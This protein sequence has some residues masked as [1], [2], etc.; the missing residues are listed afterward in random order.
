MRAA[1]ALLREKRKSMKQKTAW[2]RIFSLLCVFV[3]L[4]ISLPVNAQEDASISGENQEAPAVQE[5]ASAQQDDQQNGAAGENA[6]FG[7]MYLQNQSKQTEF[8]YETSGAYAHVAVNGNYKKKEPSVRALNIPEADGETVLEAWTVDGMNGN[9]ELAMTVQIAAMPALEWNESLAFYTVRNDRLG[10]KILAD[11]SEND[12]TEL[13][14]QHNKDTGIALVRE[15]TGE[16]LVPEQAI[17]ANDDL[18]LTGKMP[19]NAVVSAVPVKVDIDG[20]QAL[21]AYEISIYANANQ[22]KKGKTWQPADEK[23]QVHFRN[24]DFENVKGAL[25]VYH[26]KDAKAEAEKVAEVRADENG[27]I[28][29]DA[30]SFSIYAVAGVIERDI[31]VEGETWHIAVSYGSDSGIPSEGVE[32]LVKEIKEGDDNY[33]GY[34]D[35]S[36]RK[37]GIEKD[38]IGISRAFDIKIVDAKDHDRIYEPKTEVD[39]EITLVGVDLD[40]YANVGVLHFVEGR[41]TKSLTAVD[42]ENQASGNT[43]RFSTDSFS[44]YVVAGY[45][46]ETFVEA[47]DGNTY[48]I[49]VEYDENAGIPM[50]GTALRVEEILPETD[51]YN[52]YFNESIRAIGTDADHIGLSR[53][54]DIK[55][56][57]ADD[58]DHVYEPKNEVQVS[59]TL[60]GEALK[61][62]ADVHVLHF[63]DNASVSPMDS[64]VSEDTVQFTTDSFSV[65]AVNGTVH[66]RTFHFYVPNEYLEYEPYYLN[67]DFENTV[68]EQIVRSGEMPVAPQNPVNPQDQEATFAGWY[69]GNQSYTTIKQQDLIEKYDFSQPLELTEDDDVHLYA[70]FTHYYFAIFHD[71][72][73]EETGTF[74]VAFTRRLDQNGT[75]SDFFINVRQYSVAYEDPQN[76]DDTKMVF[77]GWSLA[78][79]TQPGDVF[80]DYGDQVTAVTTD[81]EGRY[82]VNETVHF[83]PIFRAVKWIS[84]YSG[85]SGTH[86]TF[87]TDTYHYDGEGPNSLPGA[88]VM[89][90]DPDASG[91]PYDFEGWYA[92]ASLDDND[93]TVVAGA[94]KIANADGSLVTNAV[95]AEA[96]IEVVSSCAANSD[97][98]IHLTNPS[99]TLYAH[100]VPRTTAKYSVVIVG[101]KAIDNVGTLPEAEQ[102]EFAEKF[103]YTGTIGDQIE[104][105]ANFEALNTFEGFNALHPGAGLTADTNATNNPYHAY[106]YKNSTYNSQTIAADGSTTIYVR[107]DWQAE[108]KPNLSGVQKTLKFVDSMDPTKT[109]PFTYQ[110]VTYTEKELAYGESLSGYI[111]VNPVSQIS[112]NGLS[113]KGWYADEACTS[114][115]ALTEDEHNSHPDW[116]YYTTMPATDLTIYAGWTREWF[117]VKI[118]PNYGELYKLDSNGEPTIGTGG[119]TWFWKE[120]GDTFQEYTTVKRDYVESDSGSWYYV[121]KD[122]AYYGYPDTWVSGE[123]PNRQTYYTQVPGDATEMSTFQYDPNVYRY[124][125][126]YEVLF[127]DNGN[128]IG[129]ASERYNFANIVDH[130]ITLRLRWMKTGVFYLEYVP[131]EGTLNKDDENETLYLELEGDSY[132]DDADVVVTRIAEPP[133]GYEF[134]GWRIRQDDSGTIYRPGQSFHLL[135]KY[136]ASV[137]GKR[138]VFLDAV[139][140]QVP[141][142]KIVYHANGGTAD[143]TV[144]ENPDNKNEVYGYPVD[145]TYK[146]YQTE[147]DLSQQTIAISR[148]V[149]NS[150]TVLSEGTWLT[151]SDGAVFVGWCEN[152]EMFFDVEKEDTYPLLDGGGTYRVG[153]N[154]GETPEEQTVHLYA[155]WAVDVNYHLNSD[156]ATAGFGTWGDPYTLETKN[157]ETFYTQRACIGSTVDW[158]PYDPV[159]IGNTFLYWAEDSQ[160]N[161]RYDFAQAIEGALDLYA[162]WGQAT[163]PIKVLNTSL[164]QY[165]YAPWTTDGDASITLT[166]EPTDPKALYGDTPDSSLSPE[167]QERQKGWKIYDGNTYILPFVTVLSNEEPKEYIL[168]RHI[169]TLR[170]NAQEGKTY[171]KLADEAEERPLAENETIYYVY[172][173]KRKVNIHYVE[174]ASDGLIYYLDGTHGSADMIVEAQAPR[175]SG[176]NLNGPGTQLRMSQMEPLP[177]APA[178]NNNILSWLNAGATGQ[179][180]GRF[181]CYCFALGTPDATGAENLFLKTN[182][183]YADDTDRPW[184]RIRNTWA[185]FQY[186]RDIPTVPTEE[187]TWRDCEHEISLYVVFYTETPTFV[188]F[189]LET[190]GLASDQFHEFDFDYW[191]DKI[192]LDSSNYGQVIEHTFTTINDTADPSDPYLYHGAGSSDPDGAG[193]I[194]LGNNKTFT[195][196]LLT[197]DAYTYRLTVAQRKK[198]DDEGFTLGLRNSEHTEP[199]AS[200]PGPAAWGTDTPWGLDPGTHNDSLIYVYTA[201][202]PTD[203]DDGS[204]DYGGTHFINVTETRASVNVEFHLAMISPDGSIAIRDDLRSDESEHYGFTLNKGE[205]KALSTALP[206]SDFLQEPLANF[207]EGAVIYGWDRH[208]PEPH[209]QGS[210]DDTVSIV[211]QYTDDVSIA[212]LPESEG[213]DLHHIYIV[214]GAGERLLQ[215]T[216]LGHQLSYHSVEGAPV[217]RLYYLYYPMLTIHYVLEDSDGTLTPIT[218]SEDGVSTVNAITYDRSPLN[219][220]GMLVTPTQ[221]VRMPIEGMTI[222]QEVGV[223]ENGNRIFNI[224]PLL[225]NGTARLDLVYYKLG[226]AVQENSDD[227]KHDTGAIN[228]PGNSG[229]GYRDGN[230]APYDAAITETLT[231]YTKIQDNKLAWKFMDEP[232]WVTIQNW[233]VIYAIYRERGY[234][235]TVVKT[236]TEDT[237]YDEPFTVRIESTAINRDT[238]PVDGTGYSTISATPANGANPGVITFEVKD[239]DA[240]TIIGL[241]PGSYIVTET[242]NEN[243]TLTA[244]IKDT[245]DSNA[246]PADI[247]V[248]GNS[249]VELSGENVL[250]ADMTLTLINA[251]EVI[252]R[253]GTRKFSTISAAVRYIEEYDADFTETIEMLVPEYLMPASDA[254]EI[255]AFLHVTL[256]TAE[257]DDDPDNKITA[258]MTSVIKRKDNLTVPMFSNLGE[259]GFENITLDGN[260]RRNGNDEIIP[261]PSALISNE[262]TLNIADGTTLQNAISSGN[263][264][265]VNS[266]KGTVNMTGGIVTGC[267]AKNGGGIYASAG[268][269]NISGGTFTDNSAEKGGAVY[270]DGSETVTVSGGSIGAEGSPNRAVD[271]GAIYMGSGTIDITGGSISYNAAA[272]SGGGIYAH[273][274]YVN[275][276]GDNATMAHNTAEENG[277]AVCMET[278]TFKLIKGSIT[279]NSAGSNGGAIWSATG[280]VEVSG[281]SMSN[282]TAGQDG[283]AVYTN[284]S[285]FIMTGGKITGNTANQNGGAVYS[286]IGSVSYTGSRG[287]EISG[288][289]ATYGNGGGIC[290]VSGAVSITNNTAKLTG[291]KAENGNGGAVW[292]GSGSATLKNS[293]IGT[294]ATTI[295]PALANKAKNGA[296]V[297]VDTG[298]VTFNEA[299]Y[300]RGNTA[301]AGGA[302]SV[303]DANARV[304]FN[305]N[306][307]IY[308]NTMAGEKSNVY[309]N[310][311]TDAILNFQS[312]GSG[313]NIGIYVSDDPVTVDGKNTT[314]LAQRG[315]PS[316]RFGIYVNNN[317]VTNKSKITNDRTPNLIVKEDAT[318]KKLYW[319]RNFNIKV[320]YVADYTRGLPF[321]GPDYT[322][323]F[324]STTN[325]TSTT[326]GGI[327]IRKADGTPPSYENAV[328]EVAED[329]RRLG[330][331]APS[332]N[333]TS[334]FGNA[335]VQQATVGD[336]H[337]DDYLT[338]ID[339]DTTNNLWN[340]KKR[341]GSIIEGGD[342]TNTVTT[343]I[344]LYTEPYYLSIENNHPTDTLVIDSLNVKVNGADKPVI[345]SAAQTGYGYVFSKND[346]I[347]NVLLPVQASDLALKPGES[348]RILLPGGKGMPYTL[349]GKYYTAYDAEHPED[350][351]ASG[352]VEYDQRLTSDADPIIVTADASVDASGFTIGGTNNDVTPSNS[353]QTHELVFYSDRQ[354]CRVVVNERIQAAGSDPDNPTYL[355]TGFVQEHAGEGATAGK[356]EYTFNS[357]RQANEFITSHHA[358]FY[359]DGDTTTVK[360]TIELLVDYMIPQSEMVNL[361]TGGGIKRDI[362]FQTSVNGHFRFHPEET[363]AEGTV[364]APRATVS[365]GSGNFDSFIKAPNGT[366]SGGDYQDK[367]TVKNLVFDGKNFGGDN[368]KGGIIKTKGWNVEIENVDFINSKAQFGGGIYIES[369]D[370]NSSDKTPRGS[371]TVKNCSFTNCECTLGLDK[372]GGGAVWTSMKT[373]TVE[374]SQFIS[375]K[376]NQQGGALF[377]YVAADGS[378]ESYTVVDGCTFEGCSAGQAAGSMESGATQVHISNT[379][380]RNSTSNAKN[381]GALNIWSG[382]S[383]NTSG[384]PTT[385]SWVYLTGCTFENCYALNGTGSNGNGGAMRSTAKYNTITDCTFINNIGNNGGAINIY[386]SKAIDTIV[387][388]CTFDGCSARCL[389]GAIWCRSNTLTIDNNTSIRNCTAPNEGGAIFHS[390]VDSTYINPANLADGSQ[391]TMVDTTIDTC[392]S[393]TRSGGGVYTSAATVSVSDSIVENC[394]T[395]AENTNG[396]GLYLAGKQTTLSG[397][398]IRNCTATGLGG[399]VYQNN[400]TKDYFTVTNHSVISGNIAQGSMEVTSNGITYQMSGGGIFTNTKTF[401]LEDSSVTDNQAAG[402]GG[403]VCQNYDNEK[404]GMMNM[405][406][407]TVTGNISGGKGGGLF[408]LTNMTLL[409][410]TAVT[411][412]RLR[413]EQEMDA[414]GVYLRNGVTLTLGEAGGDQTQ[415]MFD[416][417]GNLTVDGKPSNLRL[418][419]TTSG[420]IVNANSVKVYCG[421]GG[422]IRVVNAKKKLTRFG[423]AQGTLSNPAGFTDEHKVFWSEDGSLYGI[424]DRQ[425]DTGKKII[426]G[427]D[428][429][430][431]IT[432]G[433]GRLL[434]IDQNH[435]RPAV[436]DRLDALTAAHSTDTTTTSAFSTLRSL[437]D[438]GTTLYYAD[439]TPYTGSAYQVK[440]LVE[441]YTAEYY[442][443]VTGGT[444]KTVTLTTANSNDSLYPYRGRKGT[445]C[446]ITRSTGMTNNKPMITAKAN[447]TL[448]NVVL[449]GNRDNVAATAYTSIIRADYGTQAAIEITLGR[450]ATLQN[451]ET[452]GNG[453]GIYLNYGAKLL[454]TGGSIRNC[455][456]NNGGGVYI[457]GGSGTMTM[458]LGTITKCTATG[459]GGGVYFNKGVVD[460][461]ASPKSGMIK[462]TGG[463]I[464][465]CTAE[466]GGGIYMNGGN[467]ARRL[468][469]SGGSIAQNS[470]TGIGGGIAVGDSNARIYFS[471]APFVYQNTSSMATVG[472]APEGQDPF[473]SSYAK[474]NNIQMDQGFDRTANNPPTVIV[475]R[476]LIRGA[477]IGVYVPGDSY[478]DGLYGNHGA[479]MDPF[480]TFEGSATGGMNYFINDRNGMKGGQLDESNQDDK[481]IYWRKIYSL[482]VT[483]QV[484]S[485]D[486]ADQNSNAVYRFEVQLTGKISGSPDI[487]AE[488]FSGTYGGMIFTKGKAY[489]SLH[490]GESKVAD[491]LPLGFGYTVTELLKNDQKEHFKTSAENDMGEVSLL[492]DGSGYPYTSGEMKTTTKFNY[493]VT[494]YNLHAVCKIVGKNA[495]GQQELLYSYDAATATYTP[496]VYSALVTA[497]N[498]VNAGDSNEWYYKNES[499][500]FERFIPVSHSI[501]MLV[502]EYEMKQPASLMN[503]QKAILTTAEKNADDGFPY[504]GGS[505]SAVIKRAYTGESMLTVEDSS[506]TLGRITIDGQGN[507]FPVSCSGAI[508]E[509][510]SGAS[511]TVGNGTT[512]QNSTTSGNG[513]AICLAEGAAMNISGGPVFVNNVKTG[514]TLGQTPANGS[515]SSVYPGGTSVYQDIYIAGYSGTDA[516]SLTVTGDITSDDGSI[517]V[518]AQDD[519]HF[520]QNQQFA[521]MEGG[522]HSGLGAFRNARPDSQTQNPLKNQEGTPLYLYGVARDGK[523]YWS[524]S[525]NLTISKHITG[526]FAILTDEFSFTVSGLERD[527]QCDYARYTYDGSEWKADTGTGAKGKLTADANG[528]LSGSAL[529]LGNNQRIM[530]SIPRGITVTVTEEEY[531]CYVPGY[532]VQAAGSDPADPVGSN[533]ASNIAMNVDTAVD[534]TNNL[535]PVAPTGYHTDILP[536]LLLLVTGLL[537]AS[538]AGRRRKKER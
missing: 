314:V 360:A 136:M 55:I 98:H 284:E 500:E 473:V 68:Y 116:V 454:M 457:D 73:D 340:F 66:V 124:A 11:L 296:G 110:G 408:T 446:T 373:V 470:V 513:A 514:A 90:R 259:L 207:A 38:S 252:C 451:A 35:E 256:T 438:N 23:V 246:S 503:G 237:G 13:K 43:V 144:I 328:S 521:V 189:D 91:R 100:W 54:F 409:G 158:P 77:V 241:A 323:Q 185:G 344:F 114:P 402:S 16:A 312:L 128:E 519:P 376:A 215:L 351:I 528:K 327:Y 518:W 480:A 245:Q 50:E 380:F 249:V 310:F 198:A 83:Y 120:Y 183:R 436:F 435:V 449:D 156:S 458:M 95:L 132:A 385:D 375:C 537:L 523:V 363:N 268:T 474:A 57:D 201:M 536:F 484:V 197:T 459:N 335:F 498:K 146:D 71:Q 101:L 488:D 82:L 72:Y 193:A 366:L 70:K 342:T 448:S 434:Y 437:D 390:K 330:A 329:I 118:D 240:V 41:R 325:N 538:L 143:R 289:T 481:K 84:Y 88:S 263:G 226:A 200:Y 187:A 472:P 164:N 525:M 127:D 49:A 223:D 292:V 32:L 336:M 355:S 321:D 281:G 106:T 266:L 295:D 303:G 464:S 195:A 111:P 103:E 179:Y 287:S 285:S 33:E 31:Q 18:Y 224:P 425:D 22:M 387:S 202:E 361:S 169:E 316:T 30:D 159:D 337:Y 217:H 427:G 93:E 112:E 527:Y 262:G 162:Q 14:L 411:G 407:A 524:G 490:N 359:P 282:N 163:V 108:S 346:A 400:G 326:N 378:R 9:S 62:Y 204:P 286:N 349:S 431:K 471:G 115:V 297:F 364:T 389:G 386:N 75:G 502:H 151:R 397:T 507:S 506:L 338:R 206:V 501:E 8:Y 433:N 145:T 482:T 367:L 194:K 34:I 274:A 324:Y 119:S 440:M 313:A 150:E 489:F 242:G 231:L 7:V 148:L 175:D 59:I 149:N 374:N 504:V 222:S 218:G 424:V 254:P 463:S 191:I 414:A 487:L 398:T 526:S 51:E 199:E 154:P 36:A 60:V 298:T 3:L 477:S 432:D 406:G 113:F 415:H 64:S 475:S 131:G 168:E 357:P 307:K 393:S 238:Y 381:G 165:D 429:I 76:E 515:D 141:S 140:E 205:S 121:K 230:N 491:L 439:G 247:A 133:E 423:T 334:V 428:P 203:S 219:L 422:E 496:A 372:F 196:F 26:L 467:G 460:D 420:E 125:G 107:Y 157:G 216:E 288:N 208:N 412:N 369:V 251:P 264:A 421:I 61:N 47:S 377:H 233:P 265:A 56:V 350:G 2:N 362:T 394:Y 96:G 117:L 17:W 345:N 290:S 417:T 167:E 135:S 308:D 511:L 492:V 20:R 444:G 6:V 220:N 494:F 210:D 497:F 317:V 46:I 318:N 462:I 190:I 512:L 270:Y 1:E 181:M 392:Y 534:F 443:E 63:G 275:V 453:G 105:D 416:I 309:L 19:G 391:F 80:D 81:A 404:N 301:S 253:I 396:G 516:A 278:L 244:K 535:E 53:A 27:W 305:G 28:A 401:T 79:I 42:L 348:I 384:Q 399:G 272:A 67:S 15:S 532:V 522:P 529:R 352:T 161:Q 273:N 520:I 419:D 441:T 40:E 405:N 25:T 442:M 332:G 410:S 52:Y 174:L 69:V 126:W 279:E 12:K 395:V 86:A 92:G 99:V 505:E 180:G 445:R 258:G 173:L 339:W 333:Q 236:V 495:S 178:N 172:Y 94:V 229:N 186:A 10:D 171:V 122:R 485:D 493:Q 365:R 465:R 45:T 250:D 347:Q 21:T 5:D 483:K 239:G 469:M 320:Y 379:I 212:Y 450:N 213:N 476:G 123:N 354:I 283:G 452:T 315:V 134:V 257:P 331:V 370:K 508:V 455:S 456:A 418:P 65:Y 211:D 139:Y 39:V 382:N 466:N 129:E 102:Y 29:F 271:G 24:P 461:V 356:W 510:K 509:V 304:Y 530:I 137:Q 368:I 78:P 85:P 235:L 267:S 138:T 153:A 260:I 499:G 209:Q 388:G 184:L 478:T 104:W 261:Y 170:Y 269:V 155:I 533:T 306:V 371:L 486:P 160:G 48:R 517:W 291:N 343:L 403:G 426:W 255:P 74:P 280:S 319:V 147:Y 152:P 44:V 142:A 166:T 413:T 87:F 89:T 358:A 248:D 299:V 479:E 302:V 430:C 531:G 58:S 176:N 322:K 177:A 294:N 188:T 221:K 341:D 311:D 130:N 97:P 447:L 468:I 353:G 383:D 192:S 228:F 214:N 243:F 293:I 182:V 37:L 109:I 225:D 276:N 232:D 4:F 227:I 234:N 277:G 300:V